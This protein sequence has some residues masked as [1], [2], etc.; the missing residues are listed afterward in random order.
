[1][2]EGTANKRSIDMLPFKLRGGAVK[3]F[4]SL[5]TEE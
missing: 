1:M 2:Q 5:G 4:K 3:R